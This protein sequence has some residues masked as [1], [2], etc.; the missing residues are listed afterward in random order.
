MINAQLA[1]GRNRRSKKRVSDS[2]SFVEDADPRFRPPC[3][4]G[5]G[6]DRVSADGYAAYSLCAVLPSVRQKAFFIYRRRD[7]RIWLE[8]K[9]TVQIGDNRK[10]RIV[11]Y[12]T[13]GTPQTAE[14]GG[15][16]IAFMLY[17]ISKC[18]CVLRI[19]QKPISARICLKR[20]ITGRK[21]FSQEEWAEVLSIPGPIA[22]DQSIRN[23]SSGLR[24]CIVCHCPFAPVCR[25]GESA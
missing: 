9:G 23:D 25:K 21:P 6:T 4:N 2:E 8:G 20:M 22:I 14:N 18:L 13:G 1:A 16:S 24:H 12:K 7:G 11:D 17:E 15:F 5:G 10:T 19:S 3:G